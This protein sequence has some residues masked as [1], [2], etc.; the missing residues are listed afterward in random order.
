M[1]TPPSTADDKLLSSIRRHLDG[2][3][4]T[5]DGLVLYNLIERGL[6]RY[7]E[8]GQIERAFVNFVTSLLGRYAK[9][10]S[11]DAATRIKARLIQQRL[12]LHLISPAPAAESSSKAPPP[13]VASAPASVPTPAPTLE[14]EPAAVPE[15]DLPIETLEQQLVDRVTETFASDGTFESPPAG[16]PSSIGEFEDLKS[17]LV[18]GLDELIRER[19]ALI[20]R[21]DGATGYLKALEKDRLRLNDELS[22]ARKHSS[23]DELTGFPKRDIFI[24]SLEAEVGRV[25]RYG[26]SFALALID[27]DDMSQINTTYGREAGDA[28]LRCY[29]T[30]V[31]SEFRAYDLVARYAADEF[32]ILFPNTQKDGAMHA[33]E[34]A[35]KRVAS[36][37]VAHAGRNLRLPSF[38]S[39]LAVYAQGEKPAQL[40]KR[41]SE[42]LDNAR[43]RSRDQIVVSLPSV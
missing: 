9:D 41:A 23:V 19:H 8:T 10:T 38:S 16:A 30:E 36:I 12:A 24:R 3:K 37:F 33:L 40:L 18:N 26:F 6:K 42:A 11:Y 2:L 14:T 35:K 20:R 15:T 28:M 21:I 27:I 39:V 34:K 5:R 1:A 32:A 25:R 31:L 4:N 43:T 13:T 7:G 17:V 29:A 22:K